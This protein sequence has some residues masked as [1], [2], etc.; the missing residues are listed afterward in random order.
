MMLPLYLLSLV[1]CPWCVVRQETWGYRRRHGSPRWRSRRDRHRRPRRPRAA[2]PADPRA[3]AGRDHRGTLAVGTRLP[4]IRQLAADLDLAPNTVA[5]AYRSKPTA[6]S[7]REAA[8]A[9]SCGRH[10]PVGAHAAAHRQLEAAAT[11]CMAE[12]RRLGAP[13][14][15]IALAVARALA[16]PVP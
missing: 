11:T 14:G 3:G 9:P 6:P 2:V 4:T 1:R 8:R 5:R 13:T 10:E 12:A 16:A 15:A 7:S